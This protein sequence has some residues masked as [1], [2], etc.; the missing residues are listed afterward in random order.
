VNT[1]SD[2]DLRRFAG[3]TELQLA[4][5]RVDGTLRPY[6]TMWL[7]RVGDD[8]YVRSAGGPERPWYQHAISSGTGR[9]QAG[10]IEADV[11]F[12]QTASDAHE[13]IDAAY[14]AKYDRYG[15]RIVGSV[16]GPDAHRV[17]IQLVPEAGQ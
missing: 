3:S 7:V 13:A 8:L 15:P 10:G 6:T 14:R 12:G 4:S 1:W 17:T 5:R 16:V 11:T 9:I 2:H